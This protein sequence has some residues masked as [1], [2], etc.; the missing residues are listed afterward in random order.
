MTIYLALHGQTTGDLENRY[1]GDYDDHLTEEGQQQAKQ[2]A[3]QLK[4][5]GIEVVYSS[6][7]FRAQETATTIADGIG[8][9]VVT[10]QDLRERNSYG[11]LTGLVKDEALKT[12]PD[13]VELL[14]DVHNTVDGGEPYNDFLQRIQAA[15]G[16]ITNGNQETIA[17]VT[18][19]G[20]ISTVFR[21]ILKEGE[22]AIADCAY[23]TLQSTE[24]MFELV[25][26][27]GIVS[28]S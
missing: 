4:G 14:R 3:E 17:I 26:M 6:P 10:I 28:K 24:G 15:L 25:D 27:N 8:A 16:E 11:I 7:K 2:L 12:H 9:P 21:E 22:V 20:P 1:G 18:H 23:A 13:Q 5:K 19:G